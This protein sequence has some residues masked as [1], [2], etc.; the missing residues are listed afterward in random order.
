MHFVDGA[1]SRHQF[2]RGG[3]HCLELTG[4]WRAFANALGSASLARAPRLAELHQHRQ[5]S[6]L[7]LGQRTGLAGAALCAPS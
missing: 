6:E 7:L 4:P 2:L 3:A 5:H 1:R